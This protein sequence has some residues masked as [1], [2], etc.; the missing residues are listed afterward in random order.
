MDFKSK[1]KESPECVQFHLPVL[2]MMIRKDIEVLN[3]QP[4]RIRNEEELRKLHEELDDIE[5]NKILLNLKRV[6]EINYSNPNEFQKKLNQWRLSNLEAW[7]E[8]KKLKT[9]IDNFIIEI[10]KSQKTYSSCNLEEQKFW[11][12]VYEFIFTYGFPLTQDLLKKL[13]LNPE[14]RS[15][16]FDLMNVQSDQKDNNLINLLETTI[17][18]YKDA[19]L[20]EL[21]DEF[22]SIS[23]FNMDKFIA[24]IIKRTYQL[25]AELEERLRDSSINLDGSYYTNTA[26]LD[27]PEISPEEKPDR[28]KLGHYQNLI[29]VLIDKNPNCKK[30]YNALFDSFCFDIGDR[31]KDDDISLKLSFGTIESLIEMNLSND[32]KEVLKRNLEFLMKHILSSLQNIPKFRDCFRLCSQVY[33]KHDPEGFQQFLLSI[34][35]SEITDEKRT[36]LNYEL[37]TFMLNNLDPKRFTEV[38]ES[39]NNNKYILSSSSKTYKIAG[40]TLLI[41]LDISSYYLKFSSGGLNTSRIEGIDFSDPTKAP[42]LNIQKLKAIFQATQFKDG[43][44][45]LIKTYEHSPT[46]INGFTILSDCLD[47]N[48]KKLLVNYYKRNPADCPYPGQLPDGLQKKLT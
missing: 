45:N 33:K 7:V 5:I 13:S 40:L 16:L 42:K 36:F 27:N 3:K 24:L 43:V 37:R 28:R 12:A 30:L 2:A 19:P 34:F 18:A 1:P 6:L 39:L 8:D 44:Y 31:L 9:A 41:L 4:I 22:R 32:T 48:I 35:Q 15:K 21:I 23:D 25:K 14:T 38:I 47:D 29:A 11:K 46:G 26:V 10:F 20:P 17:E